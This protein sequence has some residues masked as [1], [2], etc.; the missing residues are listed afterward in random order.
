MSK[1]EKKELEG[2]YAAALLNSGCT[3]YVFTKPKYQVFDAYSTGF[4][5]D[6]E[7]LAEG[8][9]EF[10]AYNDPVYK[11]YSTGTT[12]KVYSDFRLDYA[13]CENLAREAAKDNRRPLLECFFWDCYMVWD[14]NKTD[15]KRKTVFGAVNKHGTDYGKKENSLLA[16][17][18]LDG[19]QGPIYRK[20]IDPETLWPYVASVIKAHH[21]DYTPSWEA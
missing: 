13:K 14:L 16:S 18:P 10:K 21:D 19:D 20:D 17:L 8:V 5:S 9:N 15:W 12:E 6:G 1:S 3:Y 7:I 4:S 2:R 11:R